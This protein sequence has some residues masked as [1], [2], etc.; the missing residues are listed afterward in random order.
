MAIKAVIFDFG[1]VISKQNLVVGS[2][3]MAQLSGIPQDVFKG[4]FGKIREQFDLGNICAKD[5]YA[6]VLA[7]AGYIAQSKDDKLC[8]KLGEIDLASW[9]DLNTETVDWALD[10]KKQGFLLGVLSNMPR[11]F[12]QKYE[13]ENAVFTNADCAIFSCHVGI[14]KPDERIYHLVLDGLGVN[15]NEAVFFDDLQANIDA[16]KK[17]GIN[18]VLF[19]SVLQA[20]KDFAKIIDCK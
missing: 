14:I 9:R 6:K 4:A 8:T 20:K 15:A 17:L 11:E 19:S 3:K 12:L 10:L 18:A 16:A 1:N 5:L 7:D 2:D 13:S